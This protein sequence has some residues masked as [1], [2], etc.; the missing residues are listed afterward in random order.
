MSA[1]IRQM[2]L[3]KRAAAV[4]EA[5]NAAAFANIVAQAKGEP[6]LVWRGEWKKDTDY[7]AGDAVSRKG[8]SYIAS[9]DS[10]N[11]APPAAGWDVLA[12]KGKD[13][14]DGIHGAQGTIF[15]SGDGGG[16]DLSALPL[17]QSDP[18]PTAIAVKQNG[19]WVQLGWLDFLVLING[20]DPIPDQVTARGI[21]ITVGG[22][23]VMVT[24]GVLVPNQIMVNGVGVTANGDPVIVTAGLLP[25]QIMVNGQG[26]TANGAP[27]VISVSS[28]QQVFVNGDLVTVNG[29][30]IEVTI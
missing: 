20:P 27:V 24:A 3:R 25:D 9:A 12:Q 16:A 2:V 23:P 28:T 26:I 21:G 7:T 1:V 17:G 13:G 5:A 15:V 11:V 8:S 18:A 19:Q 10:I 14:K 22:V 29:N 30:P 6:G 4:R